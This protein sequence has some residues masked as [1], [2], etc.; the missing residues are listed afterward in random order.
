MLSRSEG[1][2]LTVAIAA[3]VVL[4]GLLSVGFLATPNPLKLKNDPIEVSIT[5][6]TGLESSA[7]EV[8]TEVPAAH[9]GETEQPAE[10]DSPPVA[11]PEPIK[12]QPVAKPEA[13]PDVAAPKKP[14]PPA[15]AKPPSKTP[16]RREVTPSGNI[17]DPSQPD[18][19]ARTPTTGTSTKP[20][21]TVSGP[22]RASLLAQ[23]RLM[24]KPNWR[25]PTG[26][27]IDK[28]K[29]YVRIQLNQD[30]T[31][32][33]V[34]FVRQEGPTDLNRP[35]QALHKERA[36]D[37]VRKTHWDTNILKPEYYSVWGDFITYFGKW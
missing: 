23:I 8:S 18:G 17:R 37:A 27:D 13:K 20:P 35:Y 29:T 28:L 32:K 22:V 31:L 7:P 4:F 24:L 15:A 33:S 3:H 19:P 1:A 10:P 14:T 26:S 11:E 30:G 2:G 34:T 5:D 9:Q 36:I 12:P 21:G 16:P 6:E 25:A